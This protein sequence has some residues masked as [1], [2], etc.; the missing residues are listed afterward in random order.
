MKKHLLK[1]MEKTINSILLLDPESKARLHRL[2]GKVVSIELLPLH[3]KYYCLFTEHKIELLMET[4]LPVDT[5]LTG[6]PLQMMGVMLAKNHRQ[7]FFADDVTINGDAEVGQQVIELF[8][9][10]QIDWEEHLAKIIGDV[11]TQHI[12]EFIKSVKDWFKDTDQSFAR[13]VSDYVHEEK[14]WLPG[15][16]ELGDFFN[17]IDTLRMDV[18]RMEARLNQ[19]LEK[20]QL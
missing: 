19:L 13:N 3:F 16:E 17:D 12:S 20:E 18:D 4:G 11:P 15:Q 10:L 14:Q 1:P 6:T 7:Q 2:A 5:E 8:D 9:D